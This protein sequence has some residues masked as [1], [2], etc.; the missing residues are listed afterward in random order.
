MGIHTFLDGNSGSFFLLP[1]F[2]SF[3]S[4]KHEK[5]NDFTTESENL[6]YELGFSASQ[7]YF[8]VVVRGLE[9]EFNDILVS[10]FFYEVLQKSSLDFQ[11]ER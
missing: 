9:N 11:S 6:L 1:F 10:S 8:Q 4:Y 7:N 5:S 2:R 3:K